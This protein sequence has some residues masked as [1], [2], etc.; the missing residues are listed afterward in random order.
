M[1]L[2]VCIRCARGGCAFYFRNR[3]APTNR[4]LASACSP[5]PTTPT[6]TPKTPGG[7]LALCFF[8]SQLCIK[9]SFHSKPQLRWIGVGLWVLKR[10]GPAARREARVPNNNSAFA[11][12]S[13]CS[14]FLG[15]AP[16]GHGPVE[17]DLS[18]CLGKA[19]KVLKGSAL[20]SH[21]IQRGLG[22]SLGGSVGGERTPPDIEEELVHMYCRRIL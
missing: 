16:N 7:F 5:A 22:G 3:G 20:A 4:A 17:T 19:W 10:A 21:S 14:K 8:P 11:P 6:F 1:G 15:V 18:R 13:G 12:C 2:S 9:C